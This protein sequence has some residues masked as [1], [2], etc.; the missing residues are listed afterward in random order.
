M[1]A[2]VSALP[3]S[4]PLEDAVARRFRLTCAVTGWRGEARTVY[5]RGH[6]VLLAFL[7]S[8]DPA[9]ATVLHDADQRK[10]W[11]VS[12]LSITPHQNGVAIVTVDVACWSAPLAGL[13]ADACTAAEGLRDVH[14]IG[15]SLEVLSWEPAGEASLAD[16]RASRPT[17]SVTVRFVTPT[18]FGLGRAADGRQRYG[19]LPDPGLV[20]ASWARTWAAAGGSLADAGTSPEWWGERLLLRY[21]DGLGTVTVPTGKTRL[22]GFVGRVTYGWAGGE[23]AGPGLLGALASFA[24]WS[25]TGA[26]TGLGF[27]QTR[28]E[29]GGA[30][31]PAAGGA[32]DQ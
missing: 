13:L 16:L 31:R 11:A 7:R 17:E 9:R 6:A 10:P 26:K 3:V 23:S 1:A 27:G 20:V 24:E 14:A 4:D 32:D 2:D 21:C 18:F 29:V 8:V 22:T 5:G 15:H 25:G 30:I 28:R 19:L 12:P